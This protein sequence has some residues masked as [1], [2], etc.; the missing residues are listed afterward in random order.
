MTI[1]AIV[2]AAGSSRR[3]GDDKRQSQLPSGDTVLQAT[4]KLV[5]N[6]FDQ[7]LV[8]LRYGDREFANALAENFPNVTF[9]CAPDS[10]N[11]MGSSLANAIRQVGD[12]WEGA[13]IFLGDMPFIQGDSVAA[14]KRSFAAGSTAPIVI[15][16]FYGKAG[17]PV[18]FH[19]NY[20]KEI[21]ELTGD[22]G[23]RAV[24]QDH[25]DQVIEVDV[26]DGGVLKDIDH[27][28]DL[29]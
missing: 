13:A 10:A 14:L 5:S 9:Y 26:I 4:I 8:T 19:R 29:E 23:A 22:H 18:I 11:G 24:L 7:T 15:P 2:L 12:D 25:K 21:A 3:F 28:E 27:P 1:G 16:T 20:F 17:H 6:N